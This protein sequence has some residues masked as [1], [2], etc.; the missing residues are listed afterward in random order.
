MRWTA[1]VV[2]MLGACS[3]GNKESFRTLC[4]S[5]TKWPVSDACAGCVTAVKM[6]DCHCYTHP[7]LAACFATLGNLSRDCGEEA[8]RCSLACNNEC[9][10][11]DSCYAQEATCKVA[12]QANEACIVDNCAEFCK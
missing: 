12:A 4:D 9:A 8:T 3:A 5:R 7:R 2:F 1:L 11:L 10:C 6:P